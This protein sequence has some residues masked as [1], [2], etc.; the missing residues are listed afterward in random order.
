MN[1]PAARY[2]TP[3][4]IAICAGYLLVAGLYAAFTPRWQ[5]P[6]EPAHYNYAAQIRTDGCCPEIA[7]G[8]W[9][10]AT[11]ERLKSARFAPALTTNIARIQ[12]EDH[13]PP[14]YYLLVA[15]V[16]RVFGESLYVG[17]AVSVLLGLGGVV[18]AYVVGRM[19]FPAR[20]GVALTGAALVAYI[21]QHAAMLGSINNDAL[22]EGVVAGVWLVVALYLAA[23]KGK[24]PARWVRYG[25]VGVLGVFVLVAL[26]GAGRI[27]SVALLI[28]LVLLGA[29][30]ALLVPRTATGAYGWALVLGVWVG[31]AFLTKTT[32]YF[33]VGIAVMAVVLRP[34]VL[35]AQTTVAKG[36]GVAMRVMGAI[37]KGLPDMPKVE[38]PDAVKR[39]ARSF[40]WNLLKNARKVYAP[41]LRRSAGSI[42]VQAG[43]VVG[44][45]VLI[46]VV[47]WG[48]NLVVYGFPDVLGLAR[49]DAVVVGQ[50]R[51]A[52]RIAQV[53]IGGYWQGVFQT[54]FNSFWGQFGWMA[55]PLPAWAY[56]PIV[57]M[58]I[59]ALA[60]ALS[61]I[62]AA[63]RRDL[64][65][66]AWQVCMSILLGL[67]VLAALAQFA[68]YNLTFYQV[69]GR[70]LFVALIPLALA[71]AYGLDGLVAWAAR[72]WTRLAAW[73]WAV[74]PLLIAGSF[75]AFNLWLVRFVLPFLA[76]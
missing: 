72:R 69:Q 23:P 60:G 53:G 46:G 67:G 44:V 62:M 19:L 56:P 57:L 20:V 41:V 25:T 18:A 61:E 24:P 35:T 42:A 15:G 68:Y 74:M 34:V 45:A 66:T 40:G 28:A 59:G 21:P 71:T 73:A 26:V 3:L 43:V 22:A 47:W 33:T 14:L 39:H 65:P 38:L 7:P 11:L 32:A 36:A 75:G 13:Q 31:L 54:T 30:A 10:N 76:P 6:D 48:R 5:A 55:L 58:L 27:N 49:H 52:E 63:V 70:Y 64:L 9:D 4:L 2:A 17:R 29:G 50:L 51:T 16:S 1:N 8:D 12:Y 37:S